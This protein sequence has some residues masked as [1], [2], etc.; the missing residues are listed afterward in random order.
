M[1]LKFKVERFRPSFECISGASLDDCVYRIDHDMADVM[2]I[3]NSFLYKYRD[4][5]QPI[6]AED[7]ENG[8]LTY[9]N[10]LTVFF[11]P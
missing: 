10:K 11:G 1:A 8:L 7:Y 3:S 9:S 2:S 6:M 5:L 4:I